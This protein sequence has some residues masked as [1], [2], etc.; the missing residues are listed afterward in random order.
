M[1]KFL[2]RKR[3][4]LIFPFESNSV[5]NSF[6]KVLR[7]LSSSFD[8]GWMSDHLSVHK[9]CS[10]LLPK[11]LV[12]HIQLISNMQNCEISGSSYLAFSPPLLWYVGRF[13]TVVEVSLQFF[14]IR[15]RRKGRCRIWLPRIETV[16]NFPTNWANLRLLVEHIFNLLIHTPFHGYSSHL[17]WGLYSQ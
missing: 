16:S 7:W 11:W 2:Q 9:L 8:Q 12:L 6:R 14:I 13:E 5:K 15:D 10:V 4:S 1:K 3:S 17:N